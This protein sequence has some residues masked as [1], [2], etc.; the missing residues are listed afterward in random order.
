[1]VVV[2]ENLSSDHAV[3]LHVEG[4]L[5][6]PAATCDGGG[7]NSYTATL[8]CPGAGVVRCGRVDGLRPGAWVHRVRAQVAGSEEQA[9]SQRSTVLAGPP[10]GTNTVS[11]TV[12]PRTFVV[13]Q[14]DGDTFRGVLDDA[15]AFTAAAPGTR[16]LVTFDPNVFQGADHPQTILLQSTPRTKTGDVCPDDVHC[17][18]GRST[19]YCLTGS[20]LVVDALDVLARPGGVILS[21]NL[22]TRSV[23]R[24]TGSDNVLRGLELQGSMKTAQDTALDTIAFSGRGAQRNR[25]EHCIVHGPTNGDAVSVESTAG[26]PAGSGN[27]NVV[28][29][30]EITGA[31]DRGIKVTTGAYASIVNSCIHDNR[32]GCI[33]ATDGGNV[34][35]VRNV[36]QLN[37]FG[38][39]NGQ[40]DAENGLGVGVPDP[41]APLDRRRRDLPEHSAGPDRLSGGR[42]LPHRGHLPRG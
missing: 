33:Q 28:A 29:D 17:P 11:W 23:L 41:T 36:I 37:R 24:V 26:T 30:S 40:G 32:N 9:Q 38:K 6:D 16:A 21:V 4:Q 39:L 22:C 25:I 12:Y 7:A 34:T 18:D 5:L 13:H 20:G 19:S 1:M 31:E 8:D 10:P 15:A 2:A 35:A 42:R 27:D 3:T 14:A